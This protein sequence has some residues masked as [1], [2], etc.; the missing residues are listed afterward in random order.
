[1]SNKNILYR[2]GCTPRTI[3]YSQTSKG[4]EYNYGNPVLTITGRNS[5][6]ITPSTSTERKLLDNI[7]YHPQPNSKR[8]INPNFGNVESKT[9]NK[10]SKVNYSSMDNT[11]CE[12]FEKK[13]KS[14]I[15]TSRKK[16]KTYDELLHTFEE[17]KNN[18]NDLKKDK[19]KFCFYIKN[20]YDYSSGIMNLPGGYKR[21]INDV[22]DDYNNNPQKKINK[23]S[24]I[25]CFRERNIN[26][27][28]IDCL[29]PNLKKRINRPYSLTNM[30]TTYKN[31][32]HNNILGNC[33]ELL[34]SSNIIF[35][36]NNYQNN[37]AN[38][39]INDKVID[40]KFNNNKKNI[41]SYD[42]KENN[43]V[44]IINNYKNNFKR[45]YLMRKNNKMV[46][47]NNKINKTEFLNEF[48]FK[49]EASNYNSNIDIYQYINNNNNKIIPSYF[50]NIYKEKKNGLITH[51]TKRKNMNSFNKLFNEVHHQ[52]NNY[53]LME[54]YGKNYTKKN[55]SQIELH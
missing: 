25:N 27:S 37:N 26:S 48:P 21:D 22:N 6:H 30:K 18:I 8:T 41:T 35:Y 49:T 17:E 42:N 4:H 15:K 19:N 1:M 14:S 16:N 10:H 12:K 52:P 32:K 50:D 23:N 9:F 33:S 20:K 11:F 3:F 44:N 38:N 31:S 43:K 39:N 51:Y 47:K 34:Y 55:Y 53:S 7:K 45:S 46:L 24:I 40:F 54:Y 36:K 5:R 28:K 29:C 13:Q 2:S